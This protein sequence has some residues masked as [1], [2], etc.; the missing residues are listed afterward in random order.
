MLVSLGYIF[1]VALLIWIFLNLLGYGLSRLLFPGIY[2]TATGRILGII[3]ILILG[4]SFYAIIKSEGNTI[5]WLYLAGFCIAIVFLPDKKKLSEHSNK[6]LFWLDLQAFFIYILTFFWISS[7]FMPDFGS[8]ISFIFTDNLYYSKL[9]TMMIEKGVEINSYDFFSAMDN[10]VAE[11]NPYHYFE[12]WLTAFFA[13]IFHLS[14]VQVFEQ[15]IFPLFIGTSFWGLLSIFESLGGKV[16][17][18]TGPLI[19]VCLIFPGIN[20]RLLSVW[21]EK[22]IGLQ[23]HIIGLGS[24]KILPLLP[25]FFTAV[26][27]LLRG[28]KAS[29]L[30]FLALCSF[31]SVVLFPFWLTI[32]FIL[33][34]PLFQSLRNWSTSETKVTISLFLLASFFGYYYFPNNLKIDSEHKL[35]L[36]N[37]ELAIRFFKEIRFQFVVYSLL[38]INLTLAFVWIIFNHRF[39]ANDFF[40]L[41][42]YSFF[43]LAIAFLFGIAIWAFTP[44]FFDGFQFYWIIRTMIIPV[45][46][47]FALYFTLRQNKKYA[48]TFFIVVSCLIFPTGWAQQNLFQNHAHPSINQNFISQLKK[49]LPEKKLVWYGLLYSKKTYDL[50]DHPFALRHFGQEPTVINSHYFGL[51]LSILDDSVLLNLKPLQ[52]FLNENLLLKEKARSLKNGEKLSNNQIVARVVMQKEMPFVFCESRKDMIPELKPWV[53]DSLE[54][55]DNQNIIY[56][57]KK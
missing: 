7:Y 46:G 26:S 52:R 38:F 1:I 50:S 34:W 36:I 5:A 47:V 9:A 43:G 41:K 18:W 40:K 24:G 54:N 27:C 30:I 8:N 33:I 55:P 56:F 11:R 16:S 25:V 45:F 19:F 32:G 4:V 6:E 21:I 23:Y 29:G 51:P 20:T 31:F 15:I 12:L 44:T 57:L 2:Q 17:L 22:R 49:Y 3:G 53:V 35:F 37:R 42:I 39:K 14:T 10:Q 48:I 13:E 28:Y